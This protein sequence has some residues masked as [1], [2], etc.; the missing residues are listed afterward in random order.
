MPGDMSLSTLPL[1][2]SVPRVKL[3]SPVRSLA[4][5]L[6]RLNA[7]ER[8]PPVHARRMKCVRKEFALGRNP[9]WDC[10]TAL[11][12]QLLQELEKWLE[13]ASSA[14]ASWA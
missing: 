3:R 1:P 5:V 11:Q 4:V 2:E 12:T 14:S 6:V 7:S 10:G 9:V 13:S 8:S